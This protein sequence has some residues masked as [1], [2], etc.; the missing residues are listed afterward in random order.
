MNGPPDSRLAERKPPLR[1][2][3]WLTRIDQ[4]PQKPGEKAQTGKRLLKDVGRTHR[5][6]LLGVVFSGMPTDEAKPNAWVNL[7]ESGQR[8]GTSPGQTGMED[9]ERRA[10]QGRDSAQ[11]EGFLLHK[12][13]AKGVV[14]GGAVEMDS[15]CLCFGCQ[16]SFRQSFS[17][18]LKLE[19]ACWLVLQR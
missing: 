3:S 13:R 10:V 18:W 1:I 9:R 4:A 2:R 8:A 16:A 7:L 11:S 12:W 5:P 15:G 6:Q 14:C 17:R 19:M